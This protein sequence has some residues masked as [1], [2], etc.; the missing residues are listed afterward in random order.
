MDSVKCII[1]GDKYLLF[2]QFLL[3]S[4][5]NKFEKYLYRNELKFIYLGIVNKNRENLNLF[6]ILFYF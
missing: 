3:P 5:I 6:I 1:Y 2:F 4:H